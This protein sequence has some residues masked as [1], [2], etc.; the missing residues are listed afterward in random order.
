MVFFAGVLFLCVP[1]SWKIDG[2][3][4]KVIVMV[5]SVLAVTRD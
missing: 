5:H 1:E 2:R 3:L 4:C